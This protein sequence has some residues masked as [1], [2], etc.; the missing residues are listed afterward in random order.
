MTSSQGPLTSKCH[1]LGGWDI[2]VPLQY[3]TSHCHKH[4]LFCNYLSHRD[5]S[6]IDKVSL[7]IGD[8]GIRRPVDGEANSPD[9]GRSRI[10]DHK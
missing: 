1:S 10:P 8:S 5:L 9:G 7:I 4:C 2:G 6:R 3:N